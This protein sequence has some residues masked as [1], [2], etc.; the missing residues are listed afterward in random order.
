[1]RGGDDRLL[2]RSGPAAGLTRREQEVASLAAAGR[3]NRD[4]AAT[5]GVSPR[6]AENHLQRV[7][8]KLGVSSREDLA[9]ALRQD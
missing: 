8:L 1:M 2:D 5:L 6:T 9:G 7:Y 3:S 4:I